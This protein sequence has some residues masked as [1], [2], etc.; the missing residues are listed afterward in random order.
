MK[1]L[2][3]AGLLVAACAASATTTRELRDGKYWINVPKGE[4]DALNA[5]DVA[6]LVP[7]SGVQPELWKIGEGTLE[8]ATNE[9]TE[10]FVNYNADIYVTNGLMKVLSE[11]GL[12]NYTTGNAGEN[13]QTFVW[14]GAALDSAYQRPEPPNSASIG[15]TQR[16]MI[17][18][19]GT[20]YGSYGALNESVGNHIMLGKVTL[21]D[22]A[23]LGLTGKTLQIRYHKLDFN[24][25]QITS[26]GNLGFGS[27]PLANVPEVPLVISTGHTLS[28]TGTGMNSTE[29][30]HWI[31]FEND[32]IFSWDGITSATYYWGLDFVSNGTIRVANTTSSA[33]AAATNTWNGP[34]SVGPGGTLTIWFSKPNYTM[35][36]NKPVTGGGTLNLPYD[37]TLILGAASHRIRRLELPAEGRKI[38]LP[39][40]FVLPVQE[41]SLGKRDQPEGDYT[42]ANCANIVSG[43]VRVSRD[44]LVY[45]SGVTVGDDYDLS[46][47]SSVE[48]PAVVKDGS[49]NCSMTVAGNALAEFS[50]T[51]LNT[52][53][54]KARFHVDATAAESFTFVSEATWLSTNG[55]K[56]VTKWQNLGKANLYFSNFPLTS[57]STNPNNKHQSRYVSAY[58]TLQDYTVNGVT[59]TYV[60]MGEIDGK[61]DTSETCYDNWWSDSPTAAGM[62]GTAIDSAT[63]TL[64]GLEYHTVFGDA[65][66]NPTNSNRMCLFGR[67]NCAAGG[68]NVPE[69][70]PGR[71]GKD[72]MLFAEKENV[73]TAF[74][75]GHIWADNVSTNYTYTPEWGDVHVYT[76]IPTNAFVGETHSDFLGVSTIGV[77]SYARYGGARYGEMLVYSGATNTAAERARIDAYLMKKWTGRGV[78]AEMT[79]E[80]VTLKNGADLSLGCAEYADVGVGYRIGTLQGCGTLAVGEKDAL[81]VANLSFAFADRDTCDSLSTDAAVTLS[82][83]GAVTVTLPNGS[84]PRPGSYKLFEGPNATNAAAL[85]GWTLVCDDPLVTLRRD[86]NVLYA[87]VAKKGLTIL[88][89]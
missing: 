86:G 75:R 70:L 45:E 54:G 43:T 63:T 10:A 48:S 40:G 47:S 1:K 11:Y 34:I 19:A 44:A 56:G 49:G 77:D 9:T 53:L 81:F 71:R 85:D 24:G 73:T 78:G 23:K 55:L 79:L 89:R 57:T 39:E 69:Y 6:V 36:L 22:D 66:P 68:E 67:T 16:E 84:R 60:D 30:G 62:Q 35:T 18:V 42:S 21:D 29:T 46:A 83:A 88:V 87:D 51:G 15:I 5:A 17:H 31:R 38:A 64:A 65:H 7:A 13:S 61:T 8:M 58:P 59:R 2:M 50:F 37:G 82:A 27:L 72:G 25:H 41:L 12:G 32:A 4:T 20:G 26:G 28:F 74:S 80:T 52:L 76:V 14:P 3:T 33:T